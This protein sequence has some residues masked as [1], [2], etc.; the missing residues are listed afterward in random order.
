MATTLPTGEAD[1]TRDRVPELRTPRNW[2]RR[3]RR[4]A[5]A[6]SLC[7]IFRADQRNQQ[8]ATHTVGGQEDMIIEVAFELSKTRASAALS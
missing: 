8:F 1:F 5:L 6:T 4:R 3:S 2:Q 7:G